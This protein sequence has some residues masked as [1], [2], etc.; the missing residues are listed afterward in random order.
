[1]IKYDIEFDDKRLMKWVVVAYVA[2]S[3]STASS[4]EVVYS[5]RYIMQAQQVRDSLELD[6]DPMYQKYLTEQEAYAFE[7]CFV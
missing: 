3:G 5:S 6:Q 2:C 4:G 1:M 7:E